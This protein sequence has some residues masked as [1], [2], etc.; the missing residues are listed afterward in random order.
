M[1]DGVAA[2]TH[3]KDRVTSDTHYKDMVAS[4]TLYKISGFLPYRATFYIG[5]PWVSAPKGPPPDGDGG[6]ES[7]ERGRLETCT[8]GRESRGGSRNAT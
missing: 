6:M 1:K 8:Q 5:L 2:D 3:Y 7:R 4:D